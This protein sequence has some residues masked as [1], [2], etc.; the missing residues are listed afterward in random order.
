MGMVLVDKFVVFGNG[1]GLVLGGIEMRLVV[2][3]C[4]CKKDQSI[5]RS[6]SCTCNHFDKS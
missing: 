4:K 1:V 6:C 2:F 5:P 3:S